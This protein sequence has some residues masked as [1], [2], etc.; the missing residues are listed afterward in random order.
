MGRGDRG[1]G[2]SA[3][4]DPAH[5]RRRNPRD[6]PDRAH[7]LLGVDGLRLLFQQMHYHGSE[8]WVMA[9]REKILFA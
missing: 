7:R 5:R 4:P 3:A 6:D 2:A 1:D 9:A 8:S